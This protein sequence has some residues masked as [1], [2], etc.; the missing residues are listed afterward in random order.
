VA[1]STDLTF[2]IFGEDKTASKTLKGVGREAGH[3]GKAMH[4]IGVG[5]IALGSALGGLAAGGISAL[6]GGFG[7][8]LAGARDAAKITR[9][10]EQVIKSTGGAA[11]VTAGQ[12]DDLST[13]LSNKTGIDD[14]AIKSSANLLLTF[15]NIRNEVG[16]G[17]DIFNQA[18]A[19]VQD[20][21]AAL[22]QDAKASAI[23][24]GKALN[25]PVK[26]ITALQKVGVS[27]TAEQRAM[28]DALVNGGILPAL[29]AMGA[30]TVTAKVWGDTLKANNGDYDKAAATILGKWNPA[31]KKMFDHLTEGGHALEAQQMI[32]KELSKEFGGAAEAASDPMMKLGT[33]LT[34]LGEGLV[35]KLLPAID[36]AATFIVDQ[37]LPAMEQAFTWI[38]ANVIPVVKN[39]A[40]QFMKNVWP[41]LVAVGKQIAT[42]LAPATASLAKLWRETLEPALRDAMPTIKAVI[43]GVA[44]F[45]A[46]WLVFQS[47]ILGVVIP[48]FATLV[49]WILKVSKYVRDTAAGMQS[50]FV[51][52][53][54]AIYNAFRGA[55]NGIAS[56]WN[57]TVGRLSFGVPDW[58]P[59]M[60]GKG[61]DVPDIPMLAK[62]G[63]VTRPTLALIGEAGPEAVVPLSRGGMGGPQIVVN[64]NAPAGPGVGRWLL[65]EIESAMRAGQARPNML[66][67]R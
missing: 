32:L 44:A 30:G 61:W 9:L 23:Q 41:A 29:K 54:S 17:N 10:N 25:D 66:A 4:G 28:A 38:D 53:A 13:A 36:S 56:L 51:G 39:L 58:I 26:G 37:V 2:R 52:V 65:G 7:D 64:V 14:D 62:G 60:G 43:A 42:N 50:A 15:T 5:A 35:T 59:G 19:A 18:T 55:F 48:V 12:I 6:V 63:I 8:L 47:K 3:A 31:Q 1:K 27:F 34:N 21:S 16:K 46:G 49:E 33:V 20:M 45:V 57:N 11:N 40:A 22:G 67:T 24:L